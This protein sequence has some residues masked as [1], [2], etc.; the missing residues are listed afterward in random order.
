M[1]VIHRGTLPSDRL[2]EGTCTSCGT[3]V[4]YKKGEAQVS[5]DQRDNGATYVHCPVCNGF[6][7]GKLK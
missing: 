1:R 3:Q 5:P 2:Y 7:W 4:E 6:I